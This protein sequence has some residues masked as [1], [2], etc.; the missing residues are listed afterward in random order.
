MEAQVLMERDF[1]C[2]YHA[3]DIGQADIIVAWLEQR[4]IRAYVKDR[5]AAGTLQFPQIVAPRGIEVCVMD[6]SEAE[7]AR[8]LLEEHLDGILREREEA[9]SGREIEVVCEECGQTVRFPY[10]LRGRVEDCPKCGQMV[11][12]PES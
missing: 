2:V 10:E 11:D 9:P 12:V 5:F 4:G 3:G 6:G 1:V 7:H 8:A